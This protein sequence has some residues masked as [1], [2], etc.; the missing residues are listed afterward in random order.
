M[1]EM[2][3]KAERKFC[4]IGALWYI[5][6]KLLFAR[7]VEVLIYFP[8]DMKDAYMSEKRAYKWKPI[9]GWQG[10]GRSQDI[11][12]RLFNE[13][14]VLETARTLEDNDKAHMNVREMKASAS[15][16]VPVKAYMMS[17]RRGEWLPILPLHPY[18]SNSFRYRVAIRRVR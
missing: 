2:R 14:N 3:Q 13:G 7:E 15:N 1:I 5:F 12:F 10:K 6:R 16:D 4:N 17:R 8:D 11:C 18:P 9:V